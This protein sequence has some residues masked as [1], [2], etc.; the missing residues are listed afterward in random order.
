[1][2]IHSKCI[3]ILERPLVKIRA[4]CILCLMINGYSISATGQTIESDWLHKYS[5]LTMLNKYD[6]ALQGYDTVIGVYEDIGPQSILLAYAWYGKGDVLE[7]QGNYSGAVKAYDSAL[8]IDPGSSYFWF[9]RGFDLYKLGKYNG[10]IRSYDMVIRLDPTDIA[11]WYNRGEAL[12]MQG[13]YEEAIQSYDYAI[14]IN[15]QYANAWNSKGLALKALGQT[16][17]AYTAFAK[18]KEFGYKG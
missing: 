18:A 2:L 4:I 16:S 15:P 10:A 6:M 3:I 13:K 5:N 1:M 17:E 7:A 14:E 9:C 11:A 8:E 12:R